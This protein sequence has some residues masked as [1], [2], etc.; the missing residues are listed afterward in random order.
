MKH[1]GE[2]FQIEGEVQQIIRADKTD[3]YVIDRTPI[4]GHDI[5]LVDTRES[6]VSLW[7]KF[8]NFIDWLQDLSSQPDGMYKVFVEDADFSEGDDVEIEIVP[9]S[10]EWYQEVSA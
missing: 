2:T 1:Q 9:L 10:E 6:P 7:T 8:K 4:D 5:V 3:N